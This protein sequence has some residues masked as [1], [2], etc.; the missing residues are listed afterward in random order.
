VSVSFGDTHVLSDVSLVVPPGARVGVVGPNGCGK[1]T[2]L[3]V[4]AGLLAPDQGTV[5]RSPRLAT[6]GYLSQEPEPRADETVCQ[7][8]ARRSGLSAANKA[9]EAATAA[10][11]LEERG[12]AERYADALEHWLRLGGPDFEARAATVCAEFGLTAGDQP[13]ASLSGGEAARLAL[14]GIALSRFDVT[15]LDEPT[16]NLD[17]DGLELLERFVAECEGGLV[18]V[19]H[20]RAFLERTITS[21][22]EIDERTHSAVVFRGGWLAY[23][24][25]RATARRHAE[26]DHALYARR[27]KELEDRIRRQRQWAVWGVRRAAK[28]PPDHDKAQR[29]FRINR[30]EKQAAKVRAT[31]KA[32]ARL[33]V[34]DKPWEGWQLDFRV[35]TVPRSGEIVA[36]LEGAVVQR[37]T[38]R[39]GPVDLEVRWAERLAIA[40][41]NGSGKTTLLAALLGRLPLSAGSR[42][43]GPSVVVGEV[44][45]A[46]SALSGPDP[47]LVAFSTALGEDGRRASRSELR[48]GLA[49][50]GLGPSHVGRP[51]STLSPGERTRAE[52]ALLMARGVNCLVLDEP[53]NHLDLPAIEAIEAALRG[54]N[55]TLLLVT[56]DRR[57]LDNVRID[58]T[59][60]L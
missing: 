15:L 34:V 22:V 17:F 46:R 48:S 5:E 21:V 42:R 37:G 23:V 44:G 28:T 51:A 39:L 24:E 14:A 31:E 2:L 12:S 1:S 16:N 30:T 41:R 36:A 25:E 11:A 59:I 49:K 7:S 60:R 55:G 32:L 38:F 27:R 4:L 18:L 47:L 9:L 20:D 45:Q 52:L 50:F 35:A 6:A 53:T 43:I 33:P 10:V 56:H 29:D 54:W 26:E 57:L 19:S 40:G 13:T 8:L 3:R 58:R